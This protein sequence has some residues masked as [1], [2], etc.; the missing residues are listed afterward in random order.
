VGV[1]LV[2]AEGTTL[3]FTGG[4]FSSVSCSFVVVFPA[5]VLVVNVVDAT[6]DDDVCGD[7]G[8]NKSL[9]GTM[10]VTGGTVFVFGTAAVTGLETF[11]VF[12]E[13]FVVMGVGCDVVPSLLGLTGVLDVF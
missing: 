2:V 8:S 7:G 6:I 3:P 10:S 5:N 11:V 4:M 12:V 1:V 13:P 9:G